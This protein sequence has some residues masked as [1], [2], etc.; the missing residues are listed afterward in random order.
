M[1]HSILEGVSADQVRHSPFSHIVIRNCLPAPYYQELAAT[2][3]NNDQ[4]LEF[5]RNKPE[6][7]IWL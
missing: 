7:K 1:A 5:C 4:I 3:P 6:S 2:Y